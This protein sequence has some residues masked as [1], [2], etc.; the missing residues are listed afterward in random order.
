MHDDQLQ[1]AGPRS[2][3]RALIAI[4]GLTFALPFASAR[5]DDPPK[6]DPKHIDLSSLAPGG[7]A[8]RVVAPPALYAALARI[9][10]AVPAFSR[11]TK[12][13][14]SSCHYQFPRLNPF[15]RLFKL[16]GYTLTGIP[17]IG[18]PGDTAGAESL[19]LLSIPP[20][21]AMIVTSATATSTAKPGSQNGTLAFPDQMSLFL[22]GQISPNVGAF[23]QFTYAAAD[24]SFGIDNVDIRY[25]NHTTLS[26]REVIYGLTLNNNPTVQDVWNTVP[27]W[28]FPFMGSSSAP[29]PLASPLID[30]AL[31]QN[32]LGAGAYS[33]FN[34][35]LY[36][37]VTAYRSSPQGGAMPLDS[38]AENATSGLIP[39]WRVALQHE[40]D[41]TSLMI[42]TYGFAANI[43]PTGVT[44]PTNRYTDVAVDAQVERRRASGTWIGRASYIHEKQQLDALF[45]AGESTAPQLTLSTA[46]ANVEYLANSALLAYARQNLPTISSCLCGLGI[47][48][49]HEEP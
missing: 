22:A 27:A 17:T 49:K 10:A 3:H 16:N 18:Q 48:G 6:T 4:V 31:G 36:T 19:K 20:V 47:Q 35:V 39:Y 29:S 25:A 24:G 7:R 12:L 38:T 43:F 26:D 14:C 41:S 46:R 30:G 9:N 11:Q 5:A 45:A 33:L 32:V 8:D 21:A 42:G 28:G 15:G 37:E 23:T 40:S 34:K 44:G 2:F 13:A 1:T